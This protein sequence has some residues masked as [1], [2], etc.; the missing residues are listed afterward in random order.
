MSGSFAERDLQPKTS[1]TSWDAKINDTSWASHKVQF[2]LFEILKS[3]LATGWRRCIGCPK[4]QV[5]FC[6]RATNYRA[7]LRKHTA[8]HFN[9]LQLIATHTATLCNTYGNTHGNALC[10]ARQHTAVSPVPRSCLLVEQ[11]TL[12]YNTLQHSATHYTTLQH[13]ARHCSTLQHTATHCHTLATH[14]NTLQHTATHRNT[15]QQTA[16]HLQHTATHCNILQHNAPHC[17]S[18]HHT[19]PHYVLSRSQRSLVGTRIV[20]VTL[21]VDASRYIC[22]FRKR[23]LHLQKRA[24]YLRKRA[25]FDTCGIGTRNAVVTLGVDASRYIC[26]FC[27]RALHL[28]KRALYIRKRALYLLKRVFMTH[29]ILE[30]YCHNWSGCHSV[31]M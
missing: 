25:L 27:K 31:H 4:L 29:V 17:N 18:L 13:T 16:T 9:A 2:L 14:C 20:V 11:L 28:Q 26:K 24:L 10:N 6:K 30:C 19:A 22:I 15:L 5:S 12:H 8:T 7:L 1:D 23:A 21:G 3:Q